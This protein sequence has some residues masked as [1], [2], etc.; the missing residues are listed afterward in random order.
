ML[1]GDEGMR[2]EG[3]RRKL[4]LNSQFLSEIYSPQH[5]NTI[6]YLPL[7]LAL[8]PLTQKFHIEQRLS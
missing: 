4:T 2:G 6:N 8:C 3:E 7:P 5:P 1:W